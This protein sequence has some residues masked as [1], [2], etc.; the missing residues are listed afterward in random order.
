MLGGGFGVD[1]IRYLLILLRGWIIALVVGGRQKVLDRK[2]GSSDFLMV[3][4]LLLCRLILTFSVTDYLLFYFYFE[5]TLIPT[6]ILILGWGYQPERVQA[7]IYILFYTL[8]GSLPLL[9][10]L[11]SL[12]SFRGR[13]TYGL[14]ACPGLGGG[15]YHFWYFCRVFA[16]LVKLPIFIVHVWLPKAH[17]EA[18]V[19]GSMVLAGVL[20]KLGGYGLYRVLPVFLAARVR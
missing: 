4:I 18:P 7:G 16:F 13:R 8:F 19:A 14:V 17:V 10:S 11:L 20:L 5:R 12:R 2:Q 1:Y 9:V 3:N 6:F 15:T